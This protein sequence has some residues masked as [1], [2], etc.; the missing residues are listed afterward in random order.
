[1]GELISTLNVSLD[2]FIETPDHSLAC[3]RRTR[4]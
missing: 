4:T 3:P 1:M 2:A